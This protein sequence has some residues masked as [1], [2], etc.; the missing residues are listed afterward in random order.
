MAAYIALIRKD[1]DSSFGIEFPDFPGCIS[2]GATL[3]ECLRLGHEALE[4]HVSGMLEDGEDIPAP[5][6]LDE[7]DA[8]DL[9]GAVP[10]LV[11]LQPPK[12]A[13]VR[14]NVT[15]EEN[16]LKAIDRE[17]SRIGISRS[18][19]LAEAARKRLAG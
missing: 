3:D 4:F 1:P 2:A 15:I 17:A 5:R 6:T 9:V 11:T 14:L 7:V 8:G 19:F 12:G 18:G 13:A 10:A 16:L